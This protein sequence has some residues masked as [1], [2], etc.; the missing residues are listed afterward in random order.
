MSDGMGAPT[1]QYGAEVSPLWRTATDNQQFTSWASG[2]ENNSPGG[3]N[4]GFSVYSGTPA[5][6]NAS[7][8]ADPDADIFSVAY[9]KGWEDGQEASANELSSS[10]REGDVLAEAILKLNDLSSAGS[11]KFILSAVESL[12]RRC[13]ELAVPDP[14][15]LQAWAMRLAEMVDHDQKGAALILHPDDIALIDGELCKLPLR[16]DATML[17][18]NVKLSHSGGWVEKG[19]EVVLDELRTL[20]DEFSSSNTAAG[21]E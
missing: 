7:P 15:L 5:S 9:K 14:A 21:H 10:A 4:N 13:A 18:G 3:N 20:I 12:F 1:G 17:R 2:L 8:S 6:S 16:G 11:Y 19:S